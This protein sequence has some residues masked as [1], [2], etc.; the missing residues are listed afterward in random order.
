MLSK[1]KKNENANKRT[2]SQWGYRPHTARSPAPLVLYPQLS[3]SLSWATM[4][5][6]PR[7]RTQR[8]WYG[9]VIAFPAR[10]CCSIVQRKKC[11]EVLSSWRYIFWAQKP[12]LKVIQLSLSKPY[13]S[14]LPPPST[15]RIVLTQKILNLITFI[16][17]SMLRYQIST[18]L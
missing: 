4:A 10:A 7:I 3:L 5:A 14:L 12:I 17:K 13:S 2:C 6:A 9:L 1:L 16:K 15:S 18:L 11:T 8:A